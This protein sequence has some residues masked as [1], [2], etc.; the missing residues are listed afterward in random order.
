MEN[1]KVLGIRVN[2]NGM[3]TA[4][5]DIENNKINNIYY[6]FFSTPI[7]YDFSEDIAKILKWHKNHIVTTI[8][9]DRVK[10]IAIKKTERNSFMG[11][12]KDSDIQRMYIEGMVLSLAGEYSLINGNYYK[13]NLNK[14][15]D[16]NY[17]QKCIDLNETQLT[18]LE[19]DAFSVAFA[20]AIEKEILN[21]Y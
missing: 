14:I 6:E 21:D 1:E 9:S 20:I 2:T 4:L 18:E 12:P 16:S 17:Q 13:T 11:R 15:I 8:Y 3:Q 5:L 10:Y 19:L 7:I